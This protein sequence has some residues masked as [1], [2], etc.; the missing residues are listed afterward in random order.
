LQLLSVE[1]AVVVVQPAVILH[2]AVAA[3]EAEAAA[4]THKVGL[5]LLIL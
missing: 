1:A 4:V 3:A 2:L 5:L